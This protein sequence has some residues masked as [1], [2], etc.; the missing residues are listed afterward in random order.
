MNKAVHA[1]VYVIL[2]V[3]GVALYFEMNLFDKKE[4]LKDSNEQL[5]N[6]IV[7][8]SSFIEAED[9]PAAKPIEVGID[10]EPCEAREVDDPQL[11]QLLD[12]Y[13]PEYEKA[14]LTLLKWGD[15][16]AVQLR[17]LY[18]LD[19]DGNKKPDPA[20][21]GKFVTKGPGT[22]QELIDRIIERAGKQ[23]DKLNRTRT[24]LAKV[25]TKIQELA[26]EYNKLPK[27]IRLNKI[28]IEKKGKEIET[29]T[30]E[31]AAVEDQLQ[32][33]K[34]EVDD[35]KAEVT[36][37]KDE[38]A[39]AKDETEAVKED[40]NK[41]K[42]TVERLTNMLKTQA[43]TPRAAASSGSAVGG[44]QLTNSD[45][46]KVSAVDNERLY[47]VVKFDDAALDELI[48]AERNGAL[49]PHEMLVARMVKGADGKESRKVVGKVR[50][51][52]WTPKT[53]LVIVDILQDWQQAPIEV[54]DV[55]R[56]D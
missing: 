10:K 25:R 47:A 48:G 30:A 18:D 7:K 3:A 44:G 4:L 2:A 19:A 6:C 36:S 35:L 31:K 12:D 50:L 56:P 51:R 45:K 32:K 52:Q 1:L 26:G 42:E 16:Q 20:T 27:E 9:A 39:S 8:L 53:N 38:V 41:A 37:L 43:S 34:A 49:P 24:E 11:T 46:G 23:Y 40:L 15:A 22:A 5:R 54:G 28:E 29:L 55:V 14:N 21:P 33:T 13:H 17:K